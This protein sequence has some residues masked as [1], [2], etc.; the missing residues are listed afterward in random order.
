MFLNNVQIHKYLSDCF[1]V[2]FC[3]IFFFFENY[4]C[5]FETFIVKLFENQTTK[6]AVLKINKN[7]RHTNYQ[8][9]QVY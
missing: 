2:I 7:V 9:K 1:S 3:D 6:Y 5:V 8:E 4:I